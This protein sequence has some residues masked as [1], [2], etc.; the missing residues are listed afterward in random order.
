MAR[1]SKPITTPVEQ[2]KPKKHVKFLIPSESPLPISLSPVPDTPSPAYSQSSLASTAGP[3]T[4]STPNAPL[5]PHAFSPVKKNPV[6]P[7]HAVRHFA[8]PTPTSA[9]PNL[10]DLLASPGGICLDVAFPPHPD[11]LHIH[12][13][14]LSMPAT[15]PPTKIMK[16][17]AEGLPWS[18]TVEPTT[19]SSPFVTVLDVLHALYTSLH[20]PVKQAEFDANSKS[21]RDLISKAWHRRLEKIPFPSDA[22]TERARGVRRVDFLL[23]KTCIKQ[24]KYLNISGQGEVTWLVD[25]GTS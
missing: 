4:P 1:H 13:T 11:R 14:H 12:H 15:H 16:I 23:R 3:F 10:H 25:F 2:T 18:I 22:K 21:H 24:L 19:T 20:R 17:V 9:P 7:H 8:P 6:V 5:P